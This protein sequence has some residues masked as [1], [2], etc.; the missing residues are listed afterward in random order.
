MKRHWDTEELL[1]HWTLMP[2]EYDLLANKTGATRLGFALL[3][4]FFQYEAR[5]P[6]Q[7]Q[8]VPALVVPHVAKQV[9]VPVA[10]FAAYDWQSRA[11]KYHRQQIRMTLGFR[12]LTAAD[13]EALGRWLREAILPTE[14]DS[15]R[16]TAA[17]YQAVGNCG[18]S[19]PLQSA[20]PGSSA[21][22]R[23]AMKKTCHRIAQQL[24]YR[25]GTIRNVSGLL[26]SAGDTP[27][28]AQD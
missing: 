3:L 26:A 23:T 10:A 19:R 4:K 16:L 7:A 20:L 5:F 18:L 15:E 9:E 2:A 8:D 17:V 11:I 28:E 6:S 14:R 24:T 12:E 27:S 25:A 1:E 22:P 21:P 13:T